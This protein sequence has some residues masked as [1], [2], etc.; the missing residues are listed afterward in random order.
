MF[1]VFIVCF[2]RRHDEEQNRVTDRW[3]R[4]RTVK[5]E[6][7]R[8]KPN[9]RSVLACRTEPKRKPNF[10]NNFADRFCSSLI[11]GAENRNI[12]F[13]RFGFFGFDRM[14]RPTLHKF[15]QTNICQFENKI[16]FGYGQF[17]SFISGLIIF[18][19][20]IYYFMSIT[21]L[22]KKKVGPDSTI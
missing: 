18:M 16:R 17:S 10:Q 20:F 11:L 1:I 5:K 19:T 4:S 12:R 22:S 2:T 9:N 6:W 3:R 13:P 8:K 15:T 21:G 14:S 7:R